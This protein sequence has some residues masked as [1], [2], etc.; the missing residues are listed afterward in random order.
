MPV[1]VACEGVT[2]DTEAVARDAE[3]LMEALGVGAAEL[4]VLLCDDRFI[5]ALNLQW[6]GVDAPT[7]VLSFAMRE[8]EGADPDDP[9]LGDIVIS[10][11]AARRQSA[12]HGHSAA[13]EVQ[14]LLAH[15]LLHLVGY[16][17]DEDAEARAMEDEHARLLALLPER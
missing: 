14:A 13:R 4:S 7:D 15:G 12:E 8:G 2:L 3:R 10:V 17:H 6:R 11:E 9:V 16:D 1:D 5:H